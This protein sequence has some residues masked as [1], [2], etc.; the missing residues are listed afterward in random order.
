MAAAK[1]EVFIYRLLD[2]IATLFQR[3]TFHFRSPEFIGA[4]ANTA[5]CNLKSESKIASAK[6]EE[7]ISLVLVLD[8]IATIF[9]MPQSSFNP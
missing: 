3:L 9:Q 4:I 1:P 7:L 8:K 6:P 5:R 2:K